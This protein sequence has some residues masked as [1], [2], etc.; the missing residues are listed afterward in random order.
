MGHFIRFEAHRGKRVSIEGH[1]I[2]FEVH[3]GKR[4]SIEGPFIRFEIHRGKRVSIEGHFIRFEGHRGKRV[5]IEGHFIRFEGHRGK[6]VSIERHFSR[7]VKLRAVMAST[8]RTSERKGMAAARL[9]TSI[10]SEDV[11]Q[12]AQT[13][14]SCDRAY[15]LDFGRVKN[16]KGTDVR[17]AG[18]CGVGS[19]SAENSEIV[20]GGCPPATTTAGFR[21]GPGIL[22]RVTSFYPRKTVAT[23]PPIQQSFDHGR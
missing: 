20:R 22:A 14:E 5:S 13:P 4:V 3:R 11:P 17:R 21:P 2:R 19:V 23:L 12:T 10:D 16:S 9:D 7:L 8:R 6:R 18:L 1:F 15:A